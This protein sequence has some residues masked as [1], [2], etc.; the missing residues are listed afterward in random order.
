MNFLKIHK[1]KDALCYTLSVYEFFKNESKL[2]QGW[3]G[4][5][6]TKLCWHIWVEHSKLGRLDPHK[7]EGLEYVEEEPPEFDSDPN[8]IELWNKY[9]E[10]PKMYWD[11]QPKGIRSKLLTS[12]KRAQSRGAFD[13]TTDT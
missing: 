10:S 9:K 2:V 13:S 6:G 4:Y 7:T 8:I 5:S 3:V 1:V 11:L 12:L